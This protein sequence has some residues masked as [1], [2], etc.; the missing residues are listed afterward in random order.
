MRRLAPIAIV[1]CACGLPRDPKG[2]LEHVEHGTLRVGASARD[3]WVRVDD[4]GEVG[5]C[6]AELVR[7]LAD[8]LGAE[9]E[10]TTDGESRLFEQL[11][12]HRLDLVIGGITDDT[13]WH[14]EVGLS[15]PFA[16]E[17]EAAHVLAVP[18]GENAWLMAIDRFLVAHEP[19]APCG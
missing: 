11:L 19:H 8:E 14:K 15:R 13:R 17:G 2:T 7:S 5:G 18:P 9:I 1:L 10:W 6:E 4:D 12:E 3:G 16:H